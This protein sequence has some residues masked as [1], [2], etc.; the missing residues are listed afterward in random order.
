MP[1]GASEDAAALASAKSTA[2]RVSA[3]PSVGAERKHPVRSKGKK[4]GVEPSAEEGNMFTEAFDTLDVMDVVPDLTPAPPDAYAFVLCSPARWVCTSALVS[5]SRNGPDV[6]ALD[7]VVPKATSSGSRFFSAEV[8][9]P[10]LLGAG[11]DARGG[12]DPGV[13]SPLAELTRDSVAPPVPVRGA[14]VDLALT[15]RTAEL[16]AMRMSDTDRVAR[17]SCDAILAFSS[18][19]WR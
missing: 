19:R 11:R 5:T 3:R 12:A 15:W 17:D 9:N 6:A 4:V 7:F 14:A 1:L 13:P 2:S 16:S 18:S 8:S 10:E